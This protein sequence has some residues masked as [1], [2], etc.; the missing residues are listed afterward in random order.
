[1]CFAQLFHTSKRV[2]TFNFVISKHLTINF[3]VVMK[4][5]HCHMNKNIQRVVQLRTVL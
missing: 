1:M 2:F 4:T 3:A 5:G